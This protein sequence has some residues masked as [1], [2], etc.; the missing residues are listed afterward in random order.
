MERQFSVEAGQDGSE[1]TFPIETSM[2]PSP[3]VKLSEE[4][5]KHL[6]QVDLLHSLSSP[7]TFAYLSA[8]TQ[9]LESG[10]LSMLITP[11]RSHGIQISPSG[12]HTNEED[13]NG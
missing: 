8:G 1:A 5:E 10:P 7:H 3:L 11:G 6:D 2:L 12:A 4:Y 9:K 13:T